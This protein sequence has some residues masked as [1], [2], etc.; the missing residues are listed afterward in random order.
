MAFG[1]RV[2]LAMHLLFG[3]VKECEPATYSCILM[4]GIVCVGVCLRAHVGDLRR[5][6]N[7]H[8]PKQRRKQI[9]SRKVFKYSCLTFTGNFS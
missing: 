6:Q 7:L 3:S 2:G 8:A 5:K 9:D 1:S 4:H